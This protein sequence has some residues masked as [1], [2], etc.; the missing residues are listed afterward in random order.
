VSLLVSGVH[1]RLTWPIPNTG[2][3]PPAAAT[4]LI[5]LRLL[6]VGALGKKAVFFDREAARKA[7]N[8]GVVIC[9]P[10]DDKAHI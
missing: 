8:L 4:R 10:A 6:A 2:A 9:G 7:D 3:P 1:R 5:G